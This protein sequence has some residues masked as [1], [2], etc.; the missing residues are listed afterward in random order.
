MSPALH[1]KFLMMD[2]SLARQIQ[3]YL[4]PKEK[5]RAVDTV[6]DDLE[7]A[8]SQTLMLNDDYYFEKIVYMHDESK[9]SE[10]STFLN[11][12]GWVFTP[13]EELT[14][15]VPTPE[16]ELA[17]RVAHRAT[18]FD[19]LHNKKEAE[20]Q[21]FFC[22]RNGLDQSIIKY[23]FMGVR[24]NKQILPF[25]KIRPAFKISECP[26][27]LDSVNTIIPRKM[28]PCNHLLCATCSS[29]NLR[30]YNTCPVCRQEIN[31]TIEISTGEAR[32]RRKSKRS[33][34]KRSRRSRRY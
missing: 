29:E 13:E 19:W 22:I 16:E 6:L 1:I 33:R 21:I 2:H 14:F 5:I 32:Q 17:F 34:T 18:V 12:P 11:H 28:I 31:N 15:R 26:I 27:C 24:F 9:S 23:D 25:N 20:L 4:K 3:L 30:H 7:A 10:R 8:A